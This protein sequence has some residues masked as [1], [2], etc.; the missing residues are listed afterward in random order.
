VVRRA[1][2]LVQWSCAKVYWES[3]ALMN[4][5]A[6]WTSGPP[7]WRNRHGSPRYTA[8]M[9]VTRCGAPPVMTPFKNPAV[10]AKF[11]AYP[12][13]VRKKLLGLRELVFQ[14]AARQKDCGD[15]EETLKWG[16]P[17]YIAL[18]GA[19]STV[20]M[21]WKAKAPDRFVLYFNCRTNLV[22][23]FRLVFGKSLQFEGNRA[24]VLRVQSA[25]PKDVLAVC[26][27]AALTYNI[28]KR[29]QSGQ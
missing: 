24:I 21:D 14:V 8:R 9:R 17:A 5:S 7:C 1:G 28:A 11:E 20:R 27:A 26:I 18:N 3:A 4:G 13:A 19:G 2:R 16:E 25:I 29:R 10:K 15:I 22:A 12:S 6:L 23:T